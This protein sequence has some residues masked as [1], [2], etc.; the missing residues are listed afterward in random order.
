MT[1]LRAR[2][3][4]YAVVAGC[5]LLL[6]RP[7]SHALLAAAFAALLLAAALGPPTRSERIAYPLALGLAVLLLARLVGGGRAP[8]PFT[9]Y[10]VATNTLAA[11]A[12]EAF[13]RRLTYGVLLRW[14]TGVALAG[15]AVAF[16]VVHVTV[17]GVA[18]LPLDLA[19]GLLLSWQ[20]A[21]SGTWRVPALTH[22]VANLLAVV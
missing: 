20:R 3:A 15:S 22:V 5:V 7:A 16:A 9:P 19:A 1:A 10:V 8:L 18:V 17:Y 6:A 11:V 12:E 21:A 4:P 2:L 13:F 14:G